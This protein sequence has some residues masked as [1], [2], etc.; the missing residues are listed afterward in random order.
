MKSF[1]DE[2][3]ENNEA[4]YP[5]G[6]DQCPPETYTLN[7][8]GSSRIRCISCPE[9]PAGTEPTPPCGTT[10]AVRLTGLCVPCGKGTFS[11]EAD[12]TACKACSDCGLREVLSSCTTEKDAEC[13][14]CPS[15]HYEDQMTHACKHC[16]LCCGRNTAAHL[17]CI[18]SKMC[19]VNCSQMA[20]FKRKY[21]YSIFSRL[22]AKSINNSHDATSVS[23]S[24]R[25]NQQER[26]I[27]HESTNTDR[28]TLSEIVKRDISVQ[29]ADRKDTMNS[30]SS[31]TKIIFDSF[32]N[33]QL[34]AKEDEDLRFFRRPDISGSTQKEKTDNPRIQLDKESNT[35]MR[36]YLQNNAS[37][38]VETK[39]RH[40]SITLHPTVSPPT[41]ST[42]HFEKMM[43]PTEVPLAASRSGTQEPP[44]INTSSFLSSFSGTIAAFVVLALIGIIVYIMYRKCANRSRGYK[45]LKSKNSPGEQQS[46]G[47]DPAS[48]FRRFLMHVTFNKISTLGYKPKPRAAFC[49]AVNYLRKRL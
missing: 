19:K 26:P 35:S 23:S 39:N 37:N 49:N 20:K 2:L 25:K 6:L 24:L 45:K 44:L 11:V 7:E 43:P 32:I 30:N 40:V 41:P 42:T 47:K 36:K 16:S 17:E 5:D 15:L 13:K 29:V 34:T 28:P 1:W 3:Q 38:D 4:F 31:E 46:E 14:E 27:Q 21:T 8:H 33:N 18:T 12:S 9:C 48:T 22:A 10:L